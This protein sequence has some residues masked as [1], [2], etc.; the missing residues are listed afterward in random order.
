VLESTFAELYR[1]DLQAFYALWIVPALFLTWLL[2]TPSG[3]SAATSADPDVRFVYGYCLVFAIET[4]VDPFASGP[5]LRALG[6]SDG[7]LGTVVLVAFV[8][9][10]D[11]RVLLLLFRLA[12]PDASLAVSIRAAALWTLLV[13]LFAITTREL[14]AAALGGLPPQAVWLIYEIGF[15]ALA[16]WLR[17]RGL[18]AWVAADDGRRLAALRAVAGYVA[19]YYG[20]WVLSDVLI[21]G[22]GLDLGW[23]LRIVPNQLYYAFYLPFVYFQLSSR[24]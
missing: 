19:V 10:G 2:A 6:A 18:P 3:R 13:P 21:L 22:F 12:S 16:L 24:P 11:L 7:A 8:L 5:L 9:L 23:A 4:I 15:L 1:S 17:E 14:L 20:L